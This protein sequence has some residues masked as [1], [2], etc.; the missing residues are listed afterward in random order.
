MSSTPA[1]VPGSDARAQNSSSVGLNRTCQ[2]CR[3]RR[4]KCV[5]APQDLQ[6][7]QKKCARCLKLEI[8]CVF[9]PPAIKKTRK[10]NEARI[11]ELERKF[12]E[13]QSNINEVRG[14]PLVSLSG[15][16]EDSDAQLPALSDGRSPAVTSGTPDTL[17]L[18]ASPDSA[19]ADPVSRGLLSH[20]QAEGLYWAFCHNLAP[21]YPLVH[22]PE[23]STCEA[24]RGVRPALFRAILTVASSATDPCLSRAL[25]Q[26]TGRFLAEK[27]AVAGEKS[28]DLI[29]ALLIMATWQQPPEKFQGLKFSQSAQMAATMVMDLQSSNDEL[30]KIPEPENALVPS[31][32]LVETYLIL[33][34]RF[35]FVDQLYFDM[36]PWLNAA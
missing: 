1:D 24:T 4:I 29:Q 8:D 9:V 11:K 33:A 3:H 31:D 17:L 12:Q 34:L 36:G 5:I 13:I 23:S 35:P 10:R 19:T 22:V 18:S 30:Y 32:Q 6:P 27:V 25:F 2:G 7:G 15:S 21:L 14:A 26:D 20:S 16:I 28:L